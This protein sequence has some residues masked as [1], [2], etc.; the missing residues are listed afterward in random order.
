[1]NYN[2]LPIVLKIFPNWV[3]WGK[4]GTTGKA[5]KIPYNPVTGKGAKANDP[6]TW[7]DFETAVQA[8]ER[9]EYAGIGIEFHPDNGIMGIDFDH[10]IDP[11]T[12]SL[13]PWV[14]E[15]VNQFDSYT[16]ISQSGTGIHILVFGSLPQNKGIHAEQVEMYDSGRYFALTGNTE[17][18][19]DIRDAQDVVQRLYE[20]VKKPEREPIKENTEG[21]SPL[22]DAA[23]IIEKAR[24]A[25]N[26]ARF[27]KLF[28]GDT[29]DYGND[30]SRADEA[31]CDILAFYTKDPKLIDAVFRQSGLMRDKWGEPRG[32]NQTIGSI[33]I[34]KA[35]N[36]VQQTYGDKFFK[37]SENN[38]P[39]S[40]SEVSNILSPAVFVS[41]L[42]REDLTNAEKLRPVFALPDDQI[43]AYLA[44]LETRAKQEKIWNPYKTLEKTLKKEQF[45]VKKQKNTSDFPDW[46]YLDNWNNTKI[47][48]SDYVEH[49]ASEH[50]LVCE[51]G[52]LFGVDGVIPDPLIKQK[53]QR[54]IAP[55][56]P[57]DLAGKTEKLLKAL[58]N[59]QFGALPPPQMDR[60]HLANGT[61]LLDNRQLN[62]QKEMCRNRLSVQYIAGAD[63]PVWKSFTENLL[64]PEDILTLQ[65]Y[66]GYLL[67]PTT[68]AQKALYI[69]G[70][71][72]EGKSRV[73]AVCKMLLGDNCF[74][75]KLHTI[76]ERFGAA[77]LETYLAFIDDDITDA[78]FK[79]TDMLKQ[80]ITAATTIPIEKKGQQTYQGIVFSRILCC[81]NN[82]AT[83]LFDRSDGFFRRQLLLKTRKGA[84]VENPDRAL[85]EKFKAELPGILNWTLE[86][87]D[88]L[89]SH[90]WEFTESER[91]KQTLDEVKRDACNVIGFM[92]SDFVVW[93]NELCVFSKDILPAY[94]KWCHENAENPVSPRT[95]IRFIRDHYSSRARYTENIREKPTG[96][97]R[98]GFWGFACPSDKYAPAYAE[99]H[100]S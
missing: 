35:I 25:K 13:N 79:S 14:R 96:M 66:M 50:E 46:V 99:F 90:D 87:L 100:N 28:S 23:A 85:D 81:G 16:E 43:S 19:R 86:G 45:T 49:L 53:I 37:Q 71:G 2:N 93:G 52:V 5:Y 76:E 65:E 18:P 54:E 21:K 29:S 20:A 67:L 84:K 40:D 56:V 64:E 36:W 98:R 59:Q 60:I 51:N 68:R 83:A 74:M 77:N 26:G 24:K 63:C 42:S 15:W 91:A 11:E 6:S 58:K 4:K 39:V 57:S 22:S 55:Y 33:T 10:C 82:F 27:E 47:K 69:C 38:F 32:K 75:G 97:R 8:V 92:E 3:C 44:E 48:E 94:D 31:L 17:S 30:H 95:L 9:G 61:L 7:V 88:R 12:H 78:A 41:S 34:A 70:S 89:I 62:P 72:G 1:M 80:V 73:A